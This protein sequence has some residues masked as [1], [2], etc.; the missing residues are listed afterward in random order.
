MTPITVYDVA[1]E[2]GVSIA[3][4]SRVLNT[5]DKVSPATCQRD[6]RRRLTRWASCPRPRPP[7]RARKAHGRIGVLAPF[8]TY[9]SFVQRLRGVADVSRRPPSISSSIT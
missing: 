2:A 1:R 9:P 8:F 6:P 3:T 7:A 4:V 5:P